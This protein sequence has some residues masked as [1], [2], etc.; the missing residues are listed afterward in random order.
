[1]LKAKD[2]NSIPLLSGRGGSPFMTLRICL[3]LGLEWVKKFVIG[4]IIKIWNPSLN[5]LNDEK[6]L[7][8][9]W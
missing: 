4:V 9:H 1:M 7:C 5:K 2:F 6:A 3:F 8:F